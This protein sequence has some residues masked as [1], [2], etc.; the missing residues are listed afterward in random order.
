MRN[1]YG[2]LAL[3][4][5][6]ILALGVVPLAAQKKPA[7]TPPALSEATRDEIIRYVRTR[8][9]IP[10]TVKLT[11]DSL[12][13]SNYPDFYET[14][15]TVDDGTQKRAQNFYVSK[16]GR[17]LIEGNIFTLGADPRKE[18]ARAISLTDQPS[19]GPET[20]PVT[21]VEYSDL[22]CPMCAK[23]HE[24]LEKEVVPKYGDKVRIVFKEFP[25]VNIHDWALTAAIAAQCGYQLNPEMY[26]PF[27]TLVYQNQASLNAANSRDM[28][29][30]YGE[31]VG[32]DR[33]KLSTCVDSKASVQ[34]VEDAAREGNNLGVSSTPTTMV[35]GRVVVGAPP[36]PEFFKI[37][38][39]A[40]QGSK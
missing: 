1:S 23:W 19:Q 6:T 26:V 39:E 35:N 29:L 8:F 38:D 28:L 21:I 7:A 14:T 11:V 3:M 31:Q 18:L 5:G 15:I 10:D 13:P 16:N 17:Y 20:A 25:L 33:A 9:N 40:L 37:I 2:R 4:V 27:R 34:R 36:T 12:H 22:Q 32:W 24:T 30:N